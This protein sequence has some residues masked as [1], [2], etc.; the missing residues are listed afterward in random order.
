M[1]NPWDDEQAAALMALYWSKDPPA[2]VWDSVRQELVA[3]GVNPDDWRPSIRERTRKVA[4]AGL[5]GHTVKV[6]KIAES[7]VSKLKKMATRIVKAAVARDEDVIEF[8]KR[9]AER[10][11]SKA[12]KVLLAAYRDSLPKIASTRGMYGLKPKTVKLGMQACMDLRVAAGEIAADMQERKG[13]LREKIVDF[14]DQHM[15][16][17]SCLFSGLLWSCYPED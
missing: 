1:Q 12:A 4:A 14:L 6:Q 17:G 10:D 13:D 16:A 9:H 3:F 11:G 7:G 15:Q 2:A 8:L 5:Y